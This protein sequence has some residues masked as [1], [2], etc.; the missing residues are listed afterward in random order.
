[1]FNLRPHHLL[2]IQKYTGHGYDEK[3]TQHMNETVKTLS[4]GASVTL[5]EGC[6]DLCGACPN[7]ISGKCTSL[8]K[9]R[10]MDESVLKACG[11]LYGTTGEWSQLAE[12]AKTRVFQ[13]EEF[14]KICHS[15]EWF[16]L[17]EST[18]INNHIF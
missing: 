16:E 9:V 12:I 17:C 1:M 7:N 2:C 14:D 3:F 4:E 18:D 8:D 15:C 13:T 10:Y 5:R 11:L 6:D